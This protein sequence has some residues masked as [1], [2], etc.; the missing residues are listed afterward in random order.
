MF[1]HGP[2]RRSDCGRTNRKAMRRVGKTDLPLRSLPP[3]RAGPGM[4]PEI[5]AARGVTPCGSPGPPAERSACG[6]ARKLSWLGTPCCQLGEAPRLLIS[7]EMSSS[8]S[9]CCSDDGVTRVGEG[10]L[11]VWQLIYFF[12]CSTQ[13]LHFNRLD[14]ITQGGL[15]EIGC[16]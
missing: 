7:P 16:F 14:L 2:G 4:I 5:S 6:R 15:K 13:S 3:G 9:H 11:V 1:P 12:C 8:G 10:C